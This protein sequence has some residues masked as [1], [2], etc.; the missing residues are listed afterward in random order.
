MKRIRE[1]RGHIP[2]KR[3]EAV[4]HNGQSG[5]TIYR[6]KDTGLFYWPDVI[7]RFVSRD[8]NA[9]IRSEASVD[10]SDG[11]E[12]MS[13]DLFFIKRPDGKRSWFPTYDAL[14]D[15]ACET[16]FPNGSEVWAINSDGSEDFLE[17]L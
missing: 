9:L 1:V 16:S 12:L 17:D 15:A 3:L 7:G 4:H 6:V 11:V 13:A 5:A 8:L 2:G 14:M 10:A